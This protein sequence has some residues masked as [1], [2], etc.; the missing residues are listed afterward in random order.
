[1]V[2]K[3]LKLVLFTSLVILIFALFVY[4]IPLP[5]SQKGQII[6]LTTGS[7]LSSVPAPLSATPPS[8]TL[9][10]LTLEQK[11]GQLFLIGFEGQT[12]TPELEN[13][14][15]T[16]H[17]GGVLLLSRNIESEEQLKKLIKDIQNISLED[18]G[19]LL[20]VAVDQEGE[21]MS[22][23]K[24]L[25][26]QTSQ[27]KIQNVAESYEVGLKRGKELKNLGI[28]LNL[29]PVLDITQPND[30]LY[31]RSFQ[32]TPEKTGELAKSLI[33]G[34]K[35]AEILT[36]AKHFPGYGGISFNPE[37]EGL[38]VLLNI[39]E[40]SQFKI[41]LQAQPE[42]VMAAN[43]I[44]KG[45]DQNLPFSLSFQGTQFLKSEL[46]NNFLVISDDLS[47]PVLK[48]EFSLKNTVILACK[49]GIDILIVAG[50]DDPTDP[51]SAY[52]FLLEVAQN[53]EISEKRI[54]GSVSKIIKLKQNLLQ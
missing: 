46:K 16:I 23:I 9:P 36:A 47:S 34:Q 38:P 51:L 2:S 33:S 10:E 25:S 50:F 15:K 12:L 19:F 24:W 13:L 26:E 54:E 44:Y 45:I 18:N 52:N 21:P 41:S 39:P 32:K 42:M 17:P 31:S 3:S 28:N 30:F 1:M 5:K 48:S 8:A 14:I 27:S 29:A 7:N 53:G 40:I 43:V 49:S 4:K 22:R 6:D 11:I 37:R 35:A 20:F